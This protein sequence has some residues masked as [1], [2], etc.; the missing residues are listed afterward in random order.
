MM[1][2][3]LLRPQNMS[4]FAFCSTHVSFCHIRCLYSS[5]SPMIRAQAKGAFSLISI[6][7]IWPPRYIHVYAALIL[8]HTAL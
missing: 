1:L 3:G 2:V 8:S 7:P 4:T 6:N 5:A